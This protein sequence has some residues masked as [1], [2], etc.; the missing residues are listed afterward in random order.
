[1]NA[2]LLQS[3]IPA[4]ISGQIYDSSLGLPLFGAEVE[5]VA[6]GQ[7]Q[8]QAVS[9][10][11]GNYKIEKVAGGQYTVVVKLLGFVTAKRELQVKA[12]EQVRLDIGLQVGYLNDPLVIQVHGTVKQ[13]SDL[14]L[15]G[16]SIVVVRPFDQEIIIKTKTD[17]LGK[18]DLQVNDP[19]QYVLYASKPGF[20]VRAID[21][22]VKPTVPRE[23]QE[24]NFV[25]S[26]LKL[27]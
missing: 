14:P 16:A 18:Y 20:R 26:P 15:S 9:G 21:I 13:A 17:D 27:Q 12:G 6:G 23:P 10:Q 2:I 5:V 3:P 25:L 4:T 1:M 19:G 24:V 7:V 8:K 22:V 11:D